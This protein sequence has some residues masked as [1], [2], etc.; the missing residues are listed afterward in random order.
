MKLVTNQSDLSADPE[1][2][3]WLFESAQADE[4]SD[5][6]NILLQREMEEE[7]DGTVSF[8]RNYS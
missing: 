7:M 5:P 1:V 4:A 3:A 2:A 6:L 8:A